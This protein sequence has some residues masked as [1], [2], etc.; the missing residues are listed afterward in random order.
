M[1][2]PFGVSGER[3]YRTGDL[4]RWTAD[5]QLV[6][7]GRADEQVKIRGFRVEP[8]EVE[9]VLAAHPGVAQAVVVAREDVRVTS[10][11]S[12]TWCPTA[13]AV[14]LDGGLRELRGWAAAGVHGAGRGRGAGRAAA[15]G[16]REAGPRGA[17]RAGVLGCRCGPGP[18]HGAGGAAVRAFAEV[19]GLEPVGVDD[20]FF[21]LGGHSLLAMR[22]V[23]RVRAVLG[24]EVPMRALF[25]AP[26]PAGLAA[27]LARVR[28]RRGRRWCRGSVR[29]GCRCRSRSG[30]CGSWRSWRGRAR[31]TTCRWR[32]GCRAS[33]TSAA[34]GAALRDVI[35]RHESLRTVFPVVGRRAV[36]ADPGPRASWT[37]TL[38]VVAQV[39]RG[40]AGRRGGAR[41]PGTRSTSSAE[42]PVRAWLFAAGRGRARAGAG[43]APHRERRLVDGAAGAGP[44]GGVRGAVCGRAPGVGAVAGA[45]RGLRAVAAGAAG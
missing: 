32:C 8:G 43:G 35:G 17:A 2:C 45:V 27:R 26:T 22:L 12:P 24:V 1:A 6:F 19:L 31:R 38:P 39:R 11:W 25:E 37:G 41:R 7:A 9:A 4:A 3:M 23:S 44:V 13:T 36:P 16:E 14:P 42:V 5:G 33:W 30:G 18:G 15:D 21:D 29:S 10:G 20:D 28:M 34:L 40:G